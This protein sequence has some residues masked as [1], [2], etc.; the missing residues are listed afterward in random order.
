M[1]WAWI[2]VILAGCIV[3]VG[4]ST[5]YSMR[6]T[7]YLV[8]GALIRLTNGRIV[9]ATEAM[10]C[11][12]WLCKTPITERKIRLSRDTIGRDSR[13]RWQELTWWEADNKEGRV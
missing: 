10:D 5:W 13:G 6:R 8:P 2:A 3:A 1:T 7:P 9:Q 4:S 11:G 12:I